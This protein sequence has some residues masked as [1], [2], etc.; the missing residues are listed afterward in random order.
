MS[1][2]SIINHIQDQTIITGNKRDLQEDLEFVYQQGKSFLRTRFNNRQSFVGL[3]D[4]IES[5]FTEERLEDFLGSYL[6]GYVFR[7]MS[8]ELSQNDGSISPYDG[9]LLPLIQNGTLYEDCTRTDDNKIILGDYLT[10]D[11]PLP[12]EAFTEFLSVDVYIPRNPDSE[13]EFVLAIS[14]YSSPS[15]E[16]PEDVTRELF[17]MEPKEKRDAYAIYASGISAIQVALGRRPVASCMMPSLLSEITAFP[18]D[19][20]TPPEDIPGSSAY[21]YNTT[22]TSKEELEAFLTDPAPKTGQHPKFGRLFGYP[23]Y[24]VEFYTDALQKR[25]TPAI[26]K[27]TELYYKYLEGELSAE[28]VLAIDYVSYIASPEHFDEAIEHGRNIKL[29]VEEFITQYDLPEPVEKEVTPREEIAKDF[30]T[31]FN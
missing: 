11:L 19:T 13:E 14:D 25:P 23:E 15:L 8:E 22:Q 7:R 31:L 3:Y 30:D 10:I 2:Q 12:F 5:D 29:L 9:Y 26:V 4:K 28:D 20:Y 24:A 1:Y 16:T 17:S 27:E 21:I 18:V 6:V